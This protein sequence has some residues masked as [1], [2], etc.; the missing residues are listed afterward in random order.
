MSIEKLPTEE[1]R[2]QIAQVALRLMA[3][4]GM[5]KLT[6]ASLARRVGVVPS[7]I[8]HHF[9]NKDEV[10]DAVLHLLGKKLCENLMAVS[11][12]TNDPLE[13][14]RQ[15]LS[16]HI[17]LILEY[18]ALPRILFSEEVYGGSRERKARL[19]KIVMEYLEGVASIIREGQRHNQIHPELNASVLSVMFLGLVQPTAV[20]WHLSDGAFDV[21]KHVEKAWPVFLSAIIFR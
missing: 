19:N 7:A 11:E 14:L 8:Y 20:L 9:G 4:E 15:L 17:S 13:R 10:I 21:A 1:R 16:K 6:M 5:Q 18:N 12:K 2:E 3:A